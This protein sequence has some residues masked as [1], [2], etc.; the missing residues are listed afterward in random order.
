M[1][2]AILFDCDGVLVDSEIL[3]GVEVETAMLTEHGLHFD[4]HDF[5]ARFMGMSDKAFFAALN[6]HSLEQL[7][8]PLPDDFAKRCGERLYIEVSSRLTEVKGAREAVLA[9]P[10]TK[11][12]ASSGARMNGS[13]E[14]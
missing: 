1:V 4:H 13:S 7:G 6:T 9:W 2:K 5:K 11:A 3:A 14:S 8:K 10:R 12:V